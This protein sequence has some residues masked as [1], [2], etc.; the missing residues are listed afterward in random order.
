MDLVLTQ[1]QLLN[2]PTADRIMTKRL[3]MPMK[4]SLTRMAFHFVL[5]E[6]QRTMWR[7]VEMVRLVIQR[8]NIDSSHMCL[9][10][11]PTVR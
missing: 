2:N 1:E 4:K 3:P 11:K 5:S 10:P 6:P 9:H 7:H 8:L